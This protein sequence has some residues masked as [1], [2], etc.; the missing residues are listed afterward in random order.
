MIVVD[1]SV[2]IDHFN[3]RNTSSVE[4]LQRRLGSL[5]LVGDL[6]V[7]EV[8]QGFRT[9]G[10]LRKAQAVFATFEVTSMAGRD[11]A[12]AAAHNYRTLRRRG[13]TPRST[14][15]T[16]IATFCLLNGHDLL[17][18]DRGFDAFERHLGLQVVAT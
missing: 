8:L 11:I 2:W 10:G 18:D 17:H 6:I 3:G 14:I 4:L 9:E 13:I 1:S 12:I 5:V 16:L 15:D 7:I